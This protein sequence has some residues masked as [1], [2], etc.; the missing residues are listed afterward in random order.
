VKPLRAILYGSYEIAV[1]PLSNSYPT[2]K[3]LAA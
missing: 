1:L 2:G 3:I